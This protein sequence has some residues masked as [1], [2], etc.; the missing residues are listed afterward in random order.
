MDQVVVDNDANMGALA[1][2]RLGVGSGVKN[3][4][5]VKVGTGIGMGIVVNGD[6]Y[7]GSH[8][9][10]GEFGH[11]QVDQ[12]GKVC[13]CGHRGCLE[14]VVGA[15]AV[16]ADANRQRGTTAKATISDIA[17]VV[18][19]ALAGDSACVQ[20]IEH[21]G[22]QLGM[23]LARMANVLNPERIIIDG[24]LAEAGEILLGPVRQSLQQHT[25]RLIWQSLGEAHIVSGMLRAKAIA[26]GAALSTLD[27]VFSLPTVDAPQTT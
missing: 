1:E 4:L 8:G 22:K 12:N 24:G 18:E 25:V 17:Q 13:P 6:V 9:G 20:A 15:D 10:A 14:T 23:C 7:R 3:F 5:Y 19:M 11:I 2:S 21:A 27:R 16:V 26:T